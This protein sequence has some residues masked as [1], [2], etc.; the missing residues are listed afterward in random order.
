MKTPAVVEK[1]KNSGLQCSM[2]V[3]LMGVANTETQSPH[4]FKKVRK[5]H[6]EHDTNTHYYITIK[7]YE[8]I[9]EEMGTKNQRNSTLP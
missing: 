8:I 5:F 4:C 3:M 2:H 6:T 1:N 7:M 9:D